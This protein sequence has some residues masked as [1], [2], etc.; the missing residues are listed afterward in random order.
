M[1]CDPYYDPTRPAEPGRQ[2]GIVPQPVCDYCGRGHAS[3]H[4]GDD[5]ELTHGRRTNPV[6][7]AH[8]DCG[9][10][11]PP[12]NASF[13]IIRGPRG[14]KLGSIKF[15]IDPMDPSINNTF[16]INI[17]G[18]VSPTTSPL[19]NMPLVPWVDFTIQTSPFG[20]DL[21]AGFN[22]TSI[23][24]YTYNARRKGSKTNVGAIAGGVVGGVVGLALLGV[25]LWYCGLRGR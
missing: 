14:P 2:G 21:G 22:F 16:A 13:I 12:Q 3:S 15:I 6:F 24:F 11:H 8:E 4:H 1:Q 23:D 9:S 20:S 10:I 25:L 19:F 7:R 18:P 5:Y 17:N